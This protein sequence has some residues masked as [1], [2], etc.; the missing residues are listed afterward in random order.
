MQNKVTTR[1][2]R[3]KNLDK[4]QEGKVKRETTLLCVQYCTLTEWQKKNSWKWIG[5]WK[6]AE[7]IE[8]WFFSSLP[9]FNSASAQVATSH[10]FI[11]ATIVKSPELAEHGCI[12]HMRC[13]L[14]HRI[15]DTH[16]LRIVENVL[17]VCSNKSERNNNDSRHWQCVC[18]CFY[19]SFF[20]FLAPTRWYCLWLY[21]IVHHLSST[22][23]SRLFF[24][25]FFRSH[26]CVCLS[27]LV[28][29]FL[30]WRT[31]E[32]CIVLSRAKEENTSGKKE[33]HQPPPP[34]P[35]LPEYNN[36]I[37]III[38]HVNTFNMTI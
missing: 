25:C 13:V 15:L 23:F 31:A 35:L 18:V 27:L 14:S 17:S 29:A 28:V 11:E 24:P 32:K 37:G 33:Q 34:L 30:H 38:A 8:I 7:R 19:C 1:Q 2:K 22:I 12:I 20:F 10:I 6:K 36:G 26:P 21:S 9:S 16:I 5:E 4:K 3:R